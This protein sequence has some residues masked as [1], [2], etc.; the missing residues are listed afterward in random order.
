MDKSWIYHED[1]LTKEYVKGIKKFVEMAKNHLN[2]DNKIRCPCTNC[3][4]LCF[5][6][7]Q[8]VER[9]IFEKGFYQLYKKWIYHGE[10]DN[11]GEDENKGQKKQS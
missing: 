11:I 5:E 6:D 7:L 1:R 2:D 8:T 10:D 4:N 9:H 3:L